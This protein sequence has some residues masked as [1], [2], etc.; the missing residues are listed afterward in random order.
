MFI[1]RRNTIF[2]SIIEKD[3]FNDDTG[4]LRQNIIVIK[5]IQVAD[6]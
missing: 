6:L 5:R 3:G 4:D 2:Q 1:T